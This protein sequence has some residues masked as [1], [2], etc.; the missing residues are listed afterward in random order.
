MDSGGDTSTSA[1]AEVPALR[2]IAVFCGAST[3][4]TPEYAEAASSLGQ[5]LVQE[6]IR[7]VY[8]GEA[9]AR[10]MDGCPVLWAPLPRVQGYVL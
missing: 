10:A 8:G 2:S 7:L 6:G 3:G 1:A 4:V 5:A 9:Q